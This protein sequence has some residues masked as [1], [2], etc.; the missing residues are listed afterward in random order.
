RVRSF[1]RSLPMSLLIAR[2]AV[3]DR[4]RPSLHAFGITEQQW[5]VLHVLAMS[6]SGMDAT[7]LAQAALLLPPSL[8][9]ILRDLEGRRLVTRETPTRDRRRAL[10][11][12]AE[13]GAALVEAEAPF[14]DAAYARITA[15]FGQRRMDE[16]Q[17]L[18]GELVVAL[19]ETPGQAGRSPNPADKS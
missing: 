15:A 13:N 11:S 17:R 4:F 19:D 8:S 7:E 2:D 9:R 3:M 10:I 12:L 6:D 16:L 14:S 5:R 18:L 1:S